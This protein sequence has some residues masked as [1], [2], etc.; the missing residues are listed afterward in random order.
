MSDA[1]APRI[2]PVPETTGLPEDGVPGPEETAEG[3]LPDTAP[4]AADNEVDVDR[5]SADLGL[6]LP[7]EPAEAAGILA[8]S[9]L[10]S[11][12]EAGEYLAMMQRVAADFE[13]F[14][15]RV[16]RD[17]AENITRASQRLVERL[18]PALDSFDSALAYE[19]QS[20]P[21]DKILDGMRSTHA[22]LIEILAGEGLTPIPALGETFDPAVHEA[23]AG[24][25]SQGD[26]PL[27]VAQ[28]L[29]RGYTMRGRIVRPSLVSVEHG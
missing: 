8:R 6:D 1:D 21:E 3:L 19:P 23:V 14:R 24:P 4:P 7:D 2:D 28:E 9:L 26:G 5:I 27:V 11:R 10:D 12:R 15:K 13:N 25:Q 16:E 17:H 18:L 29:R 22:Q 20:P